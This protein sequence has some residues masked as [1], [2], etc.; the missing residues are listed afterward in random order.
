MP[1][2]D[3]V[4]GVAVLRFEISKI[5]FISGVTAILSL[6]A[7]VRIL[8]SSITVLR[9]SIHMGSMSPSRMIHLG[10]GAVR[11]ARSLM[12]KLNSPSCHSLVE[13]LIT[14]YS[15]SAVT[16]FGLRSV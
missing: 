8:L 14:P 13:G 5:S 12:M 4:A 16:A 9:D 11:L 15:S 1:A 2:L 7:R 10:P 6:L 3:T